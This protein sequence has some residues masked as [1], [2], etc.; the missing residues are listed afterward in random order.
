MK[1]RSGF[2][3]NSSSSSFVIAFDESK[4]GPC[5]HCGRK[6]LSILDL[7]KNSSNDDNQVVWDDAY[8][9]VQDL[10]EQIVDLR[11][12]ISKWGSKFITVGNKIESL[13]QSVIEYEQEIA[14]IEGAV[15]RFLTVAE[16]EISY[17]DDYILQEL[18]SLQKAGKLEVLSKND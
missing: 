11:T 9:R 2:V 18:N 17:H 12:E 1:V 10:K 15:K 7:I 4:L 13:K 5:P 14:L 6:D 16:V 8:Q 3:S